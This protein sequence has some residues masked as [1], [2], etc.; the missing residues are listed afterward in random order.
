MRLKVECLHIIS[1]DYASTRLKLQLTEELSSTQNS[2]ETRDQ[3]S[4]TTILKNV[5]LPIYH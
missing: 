5:G 3:V 4:I 1:N 2:M